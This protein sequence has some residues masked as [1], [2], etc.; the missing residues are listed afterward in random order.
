MENLKQFTK[1]VEKID[2]E[3]KLKQQLSESTEQE[4]LVL[5]QEM[6]TNME[7]AFEMG[8]QDITYLRLGLDLSQFKHEIEEYLEILNSV[9]G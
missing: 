1:K 3:I 8:R 6:E 2:K 5:L 7:T 9:G 4:L